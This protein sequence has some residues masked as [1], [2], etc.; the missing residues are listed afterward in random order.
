MRKTREVSRSRLTPIP[1]VM[2]ACYPQANGFVE[3]HFR[4]SKDMRFGVKLSWTIFEI[5]TRLP[6]S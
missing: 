1:A 5:P 2:I 3:E 6:A 4:D